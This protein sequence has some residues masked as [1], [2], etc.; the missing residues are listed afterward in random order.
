[1]KRQF[2]VAAS[3]L[4][5]LMPLASCQT[6]QESADDAQMRCSAS[7]LNPGTAKY[8]RCVDI[9]YSRNRE[10]A[11]QAENTAAVGAAAGLV[12][13]VLLGAAIDDNHYHHGYRRCYRCW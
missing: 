7:G 11:K 10:Q 5:L 3:I 6:P 9:N 1:M 8:R 13:G 12:G 4:V 2:M